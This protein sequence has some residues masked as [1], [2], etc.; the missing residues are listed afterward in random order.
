MGSSSSRRQAKLA[1]YHYAQGNKEAAKKTAFE[2]LDALNTKNDLIT[3]EM[4]EYEEQLLR[5]L[6]E[7]IG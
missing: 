2:G 3:A 5:K 1:Y 6:I 4:L 7:E